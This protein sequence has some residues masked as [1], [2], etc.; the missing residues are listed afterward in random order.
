MSRPESFEVAVVGGGLVG[1]AIAFGLRSLGPKLAVLDEGDVALRAARGNFGLIWVQGKGM[2]LAPYGAWTQRSA[3]EWP[4]LAGDLRGARPAS[5]W[6]WRSRAASTSVIRAKSWNNGAGARRIAGAA[7]FPALRC[8]DPRSR[9]AGET[10]PGSRDRG[11]REPSSRSTA[12]AIRSSCC[13]R[14]TRPSPA[15]V[16]PGAPAAMSCASRRTRAGSPSKPR[17]GLWP[18]RRSC[19]LPAW[20]TPGTRADGRARGAGATEQGRR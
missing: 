14:S 3:R 11:S 20:A 1:A 12:T 17:A 18:P 19:S 5:M 16:A 7:R 10:A 4:R 13:A 15:R 9:R 2:G 6:R 8:G